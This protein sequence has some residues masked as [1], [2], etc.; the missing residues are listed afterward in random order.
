MRIQENDTGV[1]LM[2]TEKSKRIWKNWYCNMSQE[3]RLC[4]L[5]YNSMTWHI[6]KIF[7]NIT[8]L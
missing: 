7:E 6:K 4:L 8:I 1:C 5:V 2:E 3:D